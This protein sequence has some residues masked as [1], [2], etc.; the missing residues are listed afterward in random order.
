MLFSRG[1]VSAPIE[2]FVAVI[3]MALSMSI[4]FY[5]MSQTQSAQCADQLRADM[6]S[7][8]QKLLDVSLG[9][10]PTSRDVSIRMAKCGDIE[11]KAIRLVHYDKAVYCRNCP[12]AAG[13]CWQIIPVSYN[14]KSKTYNPL[15][16]AITCVDMPA[17]VALTQSNALGCV[18][19]SADPCPPE[20]ELPP[21]FDAGDREGYRCGGVIDEGID[22][23]TIGQSGSRV[24]AIK[25]TKDRPVGAGSA[26]VINICAVDPRERREEG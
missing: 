10:P 18:D 1:Q 11:I 20:N 26:S 22:Y 3:I 16:D 5:V 17:A 2:L 19:L 8:S 24:W 9:S 23:S 12:N 13:Q 14:P 21:D 6:R 25:L 15:F 4:A 7:F